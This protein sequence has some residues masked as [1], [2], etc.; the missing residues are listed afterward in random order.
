MYWGVWSV[1]QAKWSAVDFDYLG[2][3]HLR[4]ARFDATRA[5]AETAAA[6]LLGGGGPAV[7]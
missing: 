4:F 7:A 5:G 3:A 2:Y 6:A 1:L